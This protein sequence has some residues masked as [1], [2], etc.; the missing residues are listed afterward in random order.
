MRENGGNRLV[1]GLDYMMD[2]LKF[3]NQP[4]RVSGESQQ[5]CVGLRCPDGTHVFCWRILTVSDESLVSNS[6]VVDNRDLY[7]VFGHL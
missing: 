3:P 6:S 7:F 2:A 4:L 1:P 5:I